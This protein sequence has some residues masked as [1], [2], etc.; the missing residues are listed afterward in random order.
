[1]TSFNMIAARAALFVAA[2]LLAVVVPFQARA[3][4]PIQQWTLPNGAEVY[5]VESHGI[6][7]VDVQIDVD[8]GARR[9]PSAKAGLASVTAGMA[10]KGVLASA[11]NPARGEAAAP[12]LDENALSEAWADLGAAFSASAGTDRLSFNLRTLT[13]PDLLAKATAL[14]ARQMAA[15]AFPAEVWTR[16]RQRI[17]ASLEESNRRPA[18]QAGRADARAVYGDHPYGLELTEATLQQITV[19]DMQA[20]Y[21]QAVRPCR[22]K[23]SLVGDVSRAQAQTLVSGLLAK[24]PQGSACAPLPAASC[25]LAV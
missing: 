20:V 22:A 14:A 10:A 1:M 11:A 13:Y 18:T 23:V 3:A 8:A 12:A 9:D 21:S 19:A 5:L 2:S 16:E 15:P 4:I 25:V 24:L 6:P 7:M 17:A